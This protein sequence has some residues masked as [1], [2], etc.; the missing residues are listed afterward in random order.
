MLDALADAVP[1]YIAPLLSL[2]APVLVLVSYLSPVV[3]IK[4]HPPL[5][6]IQPSLVLS[7]SSTN[8]TDGPSAFFGILS[9]SI[10]LQVL[11]GAYSS[12]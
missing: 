6:T 4:N 11:G 9:T 10:G 8:A 7:D 1:L 2:V 5:V 12:F 3:P